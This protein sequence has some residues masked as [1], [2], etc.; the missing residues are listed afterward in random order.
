MP[1]AALG[2][3]TARLVLQGGLLQSNA[4][5][6]SGE[7]LNARNHFNAGLELLF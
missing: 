5:L 3:S 6:E 4:Q 1:L 2:N 7:R